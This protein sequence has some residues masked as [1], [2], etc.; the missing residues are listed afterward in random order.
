MTKN[1]YYISYVIVEKQ[2]NY[3]PKSFHPNGSVLEES[4]DISVELLS[5]ILAI[6]KR[7]NEDTLPVARRLAEK[8]LENCA[9]KLKPYLTQAVES[10]S[11]SFDDYSS[12]V[13]SICEVAP[14]SLDQKDIAAEKCGDD[15]N[16]PVESPLDGTTQARFVSCFYNQL[17]KFICDCVCVWILMLLLVVRI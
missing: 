13:A 7:D 15:V 16:K 5:P 2:N 10:L 6:L 3:G 8:V 9:L 1:P 11:I 17:S 12:V 4:E 14:S